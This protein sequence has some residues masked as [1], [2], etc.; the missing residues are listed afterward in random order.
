MLG[1]PATQQACPL[2]HTCVLF[3]VAQFLRHTLELGFGLVPGARQRS[4]VGAHIPGCDPGLAACPLAFS[5][6]FMC[7]VVPENKVLPEWKAM[8]QAH[9]VGS[10]PAGGSGYS[11]VALGHLAPTWSGHRQQPAELALFS[12]PSFFQNI[13]SAPGGPKSW[14]QLNGKS[15][16]HEGG[17]C[18]CG[19]TMG[20]GWDGYLF[21]TVQVQSRQSSA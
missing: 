18:V 13:N 15:A 12:F 7:P 11:S 10:C 1:W 3:A 8:W 5:A 21:W 19:I 16:G 20:H 9:V 4:S 14:A 2:S 6:S 17:K